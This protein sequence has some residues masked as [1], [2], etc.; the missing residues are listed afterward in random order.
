[1]P[2]LA[3]KQVPVVFGPIFDRANRNSLAT[4]SR[5]EHRRSRLHTLRD[6]VEAGVLTALSAQDLREEDGLAR[7]AM[8]AIRSGVKAEKALELVT[9]APARILGIDGEVGSVEAGKRA[10][11]VVWNGAPFAATSRVVQVYLGG[12]LAHGEQ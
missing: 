10:D 9:L 7:Q 4:W 11:L 2:L 12:Q 3:A 6:L 5:S 1:M 8:L